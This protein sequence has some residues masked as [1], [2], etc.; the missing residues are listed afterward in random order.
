[1]SHQWT[2]I[3]GFV[4]HKPS[5]YASDVNKALEQ[6]QARHVER[7]LEKLEHENKKLRERIAHNVTVSV[8]Q[9]APVKQLTWHDRYERREGLRW[10]KGYRECRRMW[11]RIP[12]SNSVW[13]EYRQ[14]PKDTRNGD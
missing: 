6:V 5:T 9:G 7:K 8:V 1:M 13:F 4:A 11:Q 12:E 10:A 3:E 2:D 14:W